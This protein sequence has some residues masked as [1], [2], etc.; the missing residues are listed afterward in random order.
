MY[1]IERPT[2]WE[3]YMHLEEFANNNGY[4]ASAKMSPFEILYG[5]K[6][7]TPII[8]DI[9]VDRLMIGLATLQDMEQTVREVQK[10]MK[11]A[12]YRQKS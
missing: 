10:N 5:W 8:L 11:V 3:D 7:T 6:C 4:Q 12:Q 1:V 2:K 9:I